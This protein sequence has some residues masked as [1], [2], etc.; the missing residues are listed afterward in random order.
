M[1][2]NYNQAPGS[3]T[4]TTGKAYEPAVTPNRRYDD[5]TSVL[6]DRNAGRDRDVHGQ[7]GKDS[8][9]AG[10]GSAA[11]GAPRSEAERD[12]DDATRYEEDGRKTKH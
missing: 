7:Y 10:D 6:G 12:L 4:A 5:D 8:E 3:R 9:H 2:R 1:P 11:I